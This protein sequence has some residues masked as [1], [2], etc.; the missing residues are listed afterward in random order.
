MIEIVDKT[1]CCGCSAC[2][3]RCPKKCISLCDDVEGFSYPKVDESL[4]IDCG[5]CQRV[6]PVLNQ[7][8]KR[9]PLQVLALKNRNET[10]LL[11]SSSGGAFTILAEQVIANGGVVF[12]ARFDANYNVV[13]DFTETVGGLSLFRG[14][15][16]VQ[17]TI[18]D[19]YLRAEAFLK[20]GRHVMFTGT[21]CQILGLMKYLRKDYENLLAV[22]FV[23]HGV[24]S[25][26]VWQ[27]Y[28]NDSL[29]HHG[30]VRKNSVS[31][32]LNEIPK[33]S[34]VSFRD[35]S[36]GW[37]KYGF[38]L[39]VESAF[40]ADKNTVLPSINNKN[41]EEIREPFYKNL[42]MRAF[43]A[44]FILRPSCYSCPAKG[45]SSCSDVTLGDFWGIEREN[46]SF[47]DD[48]GVSLVMIHN[49]K[50]YAA[51][52]NCDAVEMSYTSALNGNPSIEYPVRKPINRSFFWRL[53][54]DGRT[55]SHILW[56]CQSS[57]LFT[58]LCRF[59][60][61]KLKA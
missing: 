29:Q 3:Q 57:N 40:R 16:Y 26:K 8:P 55:L 4:C 13:H 7:S 37:Q 50:Y 53:F 61:R 41:N 33:I 54:R 17:S 20:A 47:F 27:R 1:L 60:Y 14:S 34:G 43:L 36:E 12:G 2:V 15:K 28:L 46:P 18:G 44:D 21:P 31:S 51:F 58:R 32:S 6:C 56:M 10:V 24:P 19:C 42:Y 35:K 48:R 59:V 11:N 52:H 38:L 5:L 9:K 45:G 39:S 30:A 22:D 49:S 23:C 25:P